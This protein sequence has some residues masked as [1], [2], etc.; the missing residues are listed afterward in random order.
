MQ[1]D[2]FWF[3]STQWAGIFSHDSWYLQCFQILVSWNSNYKQELYKFVVLQYY[4]LLLLN[5]LIAFSRAVASD[6]LFVAWAK[7]SG[8]TNNIFSALKVCLTR[9]YKHY[10]LI[11]ALLVE[12]LYFL[13]TLVTCMLLMPVKSRIISF[14]NNFWHLLT[15]LYL[16]YV[17]GLSWNG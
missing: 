2:S 13:F 5:C 15:L 17:I 6:E 12:Y 11:G 7:S 1:S 8:T 9:H 10:R 3:F 4:F 14:C 16:M